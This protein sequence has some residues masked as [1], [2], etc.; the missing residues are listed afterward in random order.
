MWTP[1][2]GPSAHCAPLSRIHATPR[3]SPWTGPG[4]GPYD[5]RVLHRKKVHLQSRLIF[6]SSPL[7]LYPAF[8]LM[9]LLQVKSRA[10]N[11]PPARNTYPA[12]CPVEDVPSFPLIVSPSSPG[13][14]E[15]PSIPAI[16][17]G[18][19]DP[20][21]VGLTQMPHRHLSLL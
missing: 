18:P 17:G 1:S 8:P 10:W 12:S 6:L 14:E 15:A 7:P 4:T 11:S 20:T 16:L 9:F 2:M 3:R 13:K 5:P 19:V 21:G